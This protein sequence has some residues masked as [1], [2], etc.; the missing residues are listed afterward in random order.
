MQR[1]SL[2]QEAPHTLHG[3]R[4]DTV[5]ADVQLTFTCWHISTKGY[6]LAN[7]HLLTTTLKSL[8]LPLRFKKNAWILS[9]WVRR[10]KAEAVGVATDRPPWI[11]TGGGVQ[12]Q[13][14]TY[15]LGN[16]S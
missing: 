5:E 2:R 10:T 6:L 3:T 4:G 15:P 12:V 9:H 7:T 16:Y 11:W 8:L 13:S 1:S 14:L